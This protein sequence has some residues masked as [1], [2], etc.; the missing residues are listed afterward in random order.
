MSSPDEVNI[1][2]CCQACHV[3]FLRT[4]VGVMSSCVR[5]GMDPLP[6]GE[7]F[8]RVNGRPA[9]EENTLYSLTLEDWVFSCSKSVHWKTGY[10]H[11]ATM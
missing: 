8:H 5:R 10:F 4:F 1:L 6:R 7:G 3:S 9:A 2:A 11:A